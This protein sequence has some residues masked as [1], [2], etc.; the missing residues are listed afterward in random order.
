MGGVKLTCHK[1]KQKGLL[2]NANYII[3]NNVIFNDDRVYE[4]I[5]ISFIDKMLKQEHKLLFYF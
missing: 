3:K 2:Q 1:Q 4:V 5:N